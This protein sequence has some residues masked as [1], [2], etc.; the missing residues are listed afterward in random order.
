MSICRIIEKKKKEQK[1]KQ[2]IK[3]AK[4]AGTTALIGTALGITAGLL[5]APKSGKEIRKDI[6]EK[7]VKTKDDIIEKS[8]EL[9]DN[10]STKIESSKDD[11][12][13]AKEKISEYLAS[14]KQNTATNDE[15][16]QDQENE[17]ID[18]IEDNLE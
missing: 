1:R 15:E 3:I 2:N 4:A 7:T 14:K 16:S 6:T 12:M 11:L 9:K 18:R 5:F 8:K 10:I 13:T 17:I